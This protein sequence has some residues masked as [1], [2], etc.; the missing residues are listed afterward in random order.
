MTATGDHAVDVALSQIILE[1]V[2]DMRKRTGIIQ[3]LSPSKKKVKKWTRMK[4]ATKNATRMNYHDFRFYL[5]T[6]R[7]TQ[8]P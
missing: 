8:K 2:R 6:Q 4:A 7:S 1:G 3:R 5:D